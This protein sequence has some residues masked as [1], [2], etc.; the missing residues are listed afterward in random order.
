MRPLPRLGK[1]IFDLDKKSLVRGKTSTFDTTKM[2]HLR[3]R[4]LQVLPDSRDRAT[5]SR[6]LRGFL[7]SRRRGRLRLPQHFP[8]EVLQICELTKSQ[9]ASFS[10]WV[11]PN[12]CIGQRLPKSLFD[13]IARNYPGMV[14]NSPSS[15]LEHMANVVGTARLRKS[16]WP[17]ISRQRWPSTPTVSELLMMSRRGYVTTGLDRCNFT[18]PNCMTTRQV[19]ENPR[20]ATKIVANNIVGIRSSIRIPSKFL[21]WFRYQKGMLFLAVR[22]NLP[23]GL[24]RFLLSQWIKC[25]FNLWLKE[26]CR[27]KT[28]LKRHTPTD[29]VREVMGSPEL[30]LSSEFSDPQDLGRVT[31]DFVIAPMTQSMLEEMGEEFA[32]FFARLPNEA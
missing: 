22:Y 3:G 24:V 25:P 17:G 30:E 14:W 21:P 6:R 13:G 16:D 15:V 19:R 1:I 4:L 9:L 20:L 18:V 32:E 7:V 27:F 5:L 2:F 11:K 8:R 12:D 31:T 23:I 28:F 26:N 29:Y 10:Y